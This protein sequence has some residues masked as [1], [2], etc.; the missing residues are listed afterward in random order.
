MEIYIQSSVTRL[1]LCHLLLTAMQGTPHRTHRGSGD[2]CHPG[3][4]TCEEVFTLGVSLGS[5][6]G[7]V[8]YV[9]CDLE[10]SGSSP[11]TEAWL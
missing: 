8:T 1:K 6:V 4:T 5:N 10:L 9:L 2:E 7:P 3:A 11:A